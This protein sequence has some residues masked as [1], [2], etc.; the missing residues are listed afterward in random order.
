MTG[1]EV[2]MTWGWPDAES[3]EVVWLKVGLTVSTNGPWYGGPYV[4]TFV[5]M[6]NLTFVYS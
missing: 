4:R 1:G 5:D 3:S 2:A 6:D